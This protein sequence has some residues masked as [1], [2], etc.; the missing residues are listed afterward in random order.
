MPSLFSTTTAAR[1]FDLLTDREAFLRNRANNVSG[2]SATA[3]TGVMCTH[4]VEP[5]PR[6]IQAG[7]EEIVNKNAQKRN[8]FIVVGRDRPTNRASGYGGEGQTQAGMIDLVVGRG[9]SSPDSNMQIDNQ[10]NDD[11]ARI[12]I[13]Q[14]T[15]IDKNFK[16]C[17]GQV[18]D[19]RTRSGVG[20]IADGVR[21]IG[22]EGIKLVTAER[23][24]NNSKGLEINAISGIDLIAGNIDDDLQPL[25]KGANLVEYL[26]ML[27]ENVDELN[28]VVSRIVRTLSTQS[29]LLSFHTHAIVPFAPISG[30]PLTLG[31]CVKD[32]IDFGINDLILWQNKVNGMVV[33]Q[34]YLEPYGSG[35]AESSGY[36]LSRFN[37]TN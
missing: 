23:Y 19:N 2:S 6:Y 35:G 7:C 4:I 30:P 28:G 14:K 10:I 36:I 17:N 9:G 37:N 31:R 26:K 29:M 20:I 13:S 25:V 32:A 12:Y 34:G 15:D 21:I 27:Q 33:D 5:V 3:G 11:C 22:R 16:L 24:T 8:A 1:N 18:G